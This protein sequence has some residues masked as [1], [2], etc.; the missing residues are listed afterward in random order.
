MRPWKYHGNV[1]KYP[2][3]ETKTRTI[4]QLHA[5]VLMN[6]NNIKY[7][8]EGEYHI[9]KIQFNSKITQSR[10]SR[11]HKEVCSDSDKMY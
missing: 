8:H 7:T 3:K 9:T 10:L 5:Y 4:L 2:A 6:V 1:I 11:A